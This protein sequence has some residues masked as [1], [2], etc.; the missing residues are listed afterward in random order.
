MSRGSSVHGDVHACSSCEPVCWLYVI[1]RASS[2]DRTA[3]GEHTTTTHFI[4]GEFERRK[5]R[6]DVTLPSPDL[7]PCAADVAY[8][9]AI[10]S[11]RADGPATLRSTPS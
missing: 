11:R 5:R 6:R 1:E 9:G 3:T 8:D 10:L 7:G 2:V 4:N